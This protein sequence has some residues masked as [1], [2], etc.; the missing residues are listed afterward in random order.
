MLDVI[1]VVPQGSVL[2]PLLFLIF[3]N[4]ITLNINFHALLFANYM[5]INSPICS[6]NDPIQHQCDLI[7]LYIWTQTWFLKLNMSKCEILSI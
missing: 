4:D 3:I 7:H 2:G 1:S 6:D 5:K